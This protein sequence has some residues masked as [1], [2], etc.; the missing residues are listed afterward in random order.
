MDPLVLVPGCGDVTEI[1]DF[2]SPGSFPPCLSIL[3]GCAW[4]GSDRL[5]RGGNGLATAS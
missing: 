1:N 3:L 4:G 5:L 2:F